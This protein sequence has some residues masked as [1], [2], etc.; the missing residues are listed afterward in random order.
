MTA[1]PYGSWKSPIS[2]DLIVAQSHRALRGPPRSRRGLLA[3]IATA[4]NAAARSS[5]APAAT[6]PRRRSMSGPVSTSTAAA[7]GPSRTASSTSRTT[8]TSAS[9][10]WIPAPPSPR[11]HAR[12]RLP[13]RG[14]LVDPRG[15]WIGVREDHTAGGEPVNDRRT[16]LA[17]ACTSSRRATISSPRPALARRPRWRGSPGTTRTCRGTARRCIVDGA[18]ASPAA[19]RNRSS[20]PSG[21]PMARSILRLRPHRLVEPLPLRC[22]HGRRGAPSRRW[23]RS[24]AQPQWVLRDVDLRLRRPGADR[25]RVHRGRPRPAGRID[26]TTGAVTPIETPYTDISSRARRRRPRGLPRRSPTL[27]A[28]HRR[29]STSRRGSSEVLKKID[30]RRRRSDRARYFTGVE[31]IEFPDRGPH[32]ARA[33]STRL[34]PG[35]RGARR[36]DAAAAGQVPRRADRRPLERARPAHPVLDQPRHRGA[37]REL[38]RQHRLRPRLPP[39]ARTAAGASSTSTTASTARAILA[40]RGWADP[41]AA[42]SRGGSAGGYTTLAALTFRDF[43][44]GGASHY[45][46]SDLERWRATRTSSSRATWTG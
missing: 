11:H 45:G 41:D 18:A 43:F 39:A 2:S 15:R 13:L 29:S 7:H 19:P 16:R 30:H 46:V 26:L 10:A 33:S 34:Q 8:P 1:A 4:R 20:S 44:R 25:L 17:R 24:S 22:G 42:R 23:R 12:R 38:R 5:C 36:R 31:P 40:E 3:G 14:R 27:P 32:R 37:R 21:R 9:T 28:Q 35:L 6:S